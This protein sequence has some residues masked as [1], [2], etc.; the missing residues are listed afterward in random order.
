[1]STAT[2]MPSERSAGGFT[3]TQGR[4]FAPASASR[5]SRLPL[6]L[7]LLVAMLLTGVMRA[8]VLARHDV[9]QPKRVA[10]SRAAGMD[11]FALG[12]ILAYDAMRYDW[13]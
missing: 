2:R 10:A 6:V 13:R 12:L 1:M 4:R 5:P 3:G 7:V 11:T 8:I 9:L